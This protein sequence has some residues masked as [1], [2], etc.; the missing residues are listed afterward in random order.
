MGLNTSIVSVY[1]VPQMRCPVNAYMA[2][3]CMQTFNKT[4][5]FS[6]PGRA[7][8][9]FLAFLLAHAPLWALDETPESA[10]HIFAMEEVV[11]TATRSF[12]D[13]TRI[14][15]NIAIVTR[16][17]L[18]NMP[19]S[20]VAEVLQYVPGV[21]VE[22]NG[23]PGSDA[24]TVRIQGSEARHVAVYQD[25]V[26]LNQQANPM[27][28]LS[29]I[30]VTAIDRIEIYKGA[31]SSSW[32]SAL[33]GVINIITK[34]PDDGK[35]FHI[36]AKASYGDFNT[37]KAY[38]NISGTIDRLGWLF[39][40]THEESDG[41]AEKTDYSQDAVYAKF[42]YDPKTGS[43]LNFVY[44]YD[45][46]R[47]SDPAPAFADFWD[48]IQRRRSYQRVLF[49]TFPNDDVALTLEARHHKF[50][51]N[52]ED[53]YPSSREVYNEYKDELWG[54]SMKIQWDT[55]DT[56]NLTAGFDGDWGR[57][58]WNNYANEY[59]PGYWA[60]YANET[61]TMGNL[62]F[63]AGLRYDDNKDFGSALSPSGG[64]VYRIEEL[65][66]ALIRAQVA[67][68][69]STPPSPWVHDP[70]LGNSNLE[71]ETAIN[72]QAGGEILFLKNVRFEINL[73]HT[74]VKDLIR[75]DREAEQ[76][77]NVDEATRRGIEGELSVELDFGLKLSMG[78]SHVDVKDKRNNE[79][80][81]NIP[82]ALYNISAVYIN[83]SMTHS[84]MG[85]YIDHNSTFPETRDKVFIFDYGLRWG[86][87]FGK[88][89]G[90]ASLY[91][92]VYNLL[93]TTYL[94]R[95][96]WPKPGRWAEA[97]IRLEY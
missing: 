93:D 9:F 18:E 85:K 72:Y 38:G 12:L 25:G 82:K 96:V 3:N 45:E 34:Q 36:D 26:P 28:D 41:F 91:L 97:G 7:L 74:E 11:V 42:N 2:L 66:K 35:P 49:D 23:G 68:G 15:A 8:P 44:S 75:Y 52:I 14:A 43:R 33:G 94:Y 87:P 5:L 64:V 61:F 16:E 67:K 84:F 47:N 54:G 50:D 70:V 29:Y 60:A 69:F 51:S 27:T 6:I 19:A 80:I 76:Y 13:E 73:F 22:F 24:S 79:V 48:D 40:F 81:P 95:N 59:D 21:Y 55:W 90:K 77:L 92:N 71:P 30:P 20:N 57:Y 56:H 83:Q 32:G 89:H 31:A 65:N 1:R 88:K 53:V 4:I 62:A 63:N 78:G 39:S 58:D 10:N 37:T 46:G 86:L 17:D